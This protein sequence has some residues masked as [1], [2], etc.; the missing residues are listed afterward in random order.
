MNIRILRACGIAGVGY[1]VGAIVDVP[2]RDARYVVAI[3][4]AVRH[5]AAP[6]EP[7]PATVTT[8]TAEAVVP[9]KR[10]RGK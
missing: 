7:A 10:H 1:P 2:D 4:K 6:V 8:K 5:E 3:G 9:T